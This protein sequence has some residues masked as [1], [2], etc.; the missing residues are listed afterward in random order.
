LFQAI[1]DSNNSNATKETSQAIKTGIMVYVFQKVF[2][3][4]QG[5][6]YAY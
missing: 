2:L 6:C 1:L 3:Q 5:H 4:D